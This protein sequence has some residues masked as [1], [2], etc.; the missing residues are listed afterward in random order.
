MGAALP[1]KHFPPRLGSIVVMGALPVAAEPACC[2]NKA[3]G[4]TKTTKNAKATFTE[5][6]DTE[7][8]LMDSLER[9]CVKPTLSLQP[10]DT[11]KLNFIKRS[12]TSFRI[13]AGLP[14]WQ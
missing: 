13:L 12:G 5:V 4:G 7:S 1:W 3:A 10:V 9:R 2:A 8:S 14:N 6:F 11:I